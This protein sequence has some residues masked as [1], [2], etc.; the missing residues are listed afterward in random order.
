MGKI[1]G[2]AMIALSAIWLSAEYLRRCRHRGAMLLALSEDMGHLAA[3]VLFRRCAFPQLLEELAARPL[4]GRYYREMLCLLDGGT[5]LESAW[6]SAF[7]D[8]SPAPPRPEFSADA[9]KLSASL[10]YLQEHFTRQWEADCAARR[11]QR[12][13]CCGASLAAAGLL[14]VLL[15]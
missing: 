15:L 9:Q 14:I 3:S 13:L 4:T 12:R 6:Q 8:L 7:S 10:A 2:A 5:P 1:L 11:T